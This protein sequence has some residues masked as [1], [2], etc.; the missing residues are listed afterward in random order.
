[1][2]ELR[3]TYLYAFLLFALLLVSC[4]TRN[5]YTGYRELLM[6]SQTPK[7][8]YG[9]WCPEGF[10]QF[11]HFERTILTD[12]ITILKFDKNDR[13]EFYGGISVGEDYERFENMKIMTYNGDD[14]FCVT[15]RN[16]GN[17]KGN[18]LH[19]YYIDKKDCTLHPIEI[20]KAYSLYSQ[21]LPDSLFIWND[22]IIDYDDNSIVSEFYIWKRTD[23]HPTPTG[24]KV[25]VIYDI[26]KT[27]KR[28]Y[29]LYPKEMNFTEGVFEL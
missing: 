26:E 16:S 25:S 29:R 11:Q 2:L 14:F 7:E 20:V 1:M 10:L 5:T 17:A 24:G 22:E 8:V 21:T 3:I 15:A 12:T 9:Y 28:K 6:Y 27:D 13:F 18:T 23:I 19:M 4:G